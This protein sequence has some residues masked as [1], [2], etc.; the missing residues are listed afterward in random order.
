[1]RKIANILLWEEVTFEVATLDMSLNET[2]NSP[3]LGKV[4]YR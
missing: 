1:M 4:D 2:Q 3:V